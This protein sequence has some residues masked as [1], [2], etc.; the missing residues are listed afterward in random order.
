MTSWLKSNIFVKNYMTIMLPTMKITPWQFLSMAQEKNYQLLKFTI[1]K[2]PVQFHK[3][4]ERFQQSTKS[5]RFATTFKRNVSAILWEQKCPCIHVLPIGRPSE[6]KNKK[7]EEMKARK[8]AIHE[9]FSQG[10]ITKKLKC[11]LDQVM[12]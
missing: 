6:I 3:R 11:V 5:R 2:D 9:L 8:K 12:S 10:K 1:W 7:G 4:T